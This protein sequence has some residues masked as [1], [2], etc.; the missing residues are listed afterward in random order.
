MKHVIP[1]LDELTVLLS[2]N[3]IALEGQVP[4]GFGV[5]CF[6]KLPIEWRALDG[7]KLH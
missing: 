2:C 7:M 6:V 1:L 3:E 4:G 5:G